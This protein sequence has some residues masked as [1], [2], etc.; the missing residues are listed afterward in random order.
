MRIHEK[1]QNPMS[2]HL[3]YFEHWAYLSRTFHSF[4]H[5]KI[6]NGKYSEEAQSNIPFYW[7]QVVYAV[8]ICQPQHMSSANKKNEIN[9]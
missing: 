8:F 1:Y 6:Y 4:P 5:G 2:W 9:P 7:T 3:Y